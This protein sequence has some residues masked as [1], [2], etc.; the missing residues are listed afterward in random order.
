MSEERDA[1]YWLEKRCEELAAENR[2]VRSA[3]IDLRVDFGMRLDKLERANAALDTA[4]SLAR[5][6]GP[7]AVG[8]TA[9]L[10]SLLR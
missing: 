1:V 5:W 6:A 10:I 9:A 3:L 4:V 7:L 8:I 2:D